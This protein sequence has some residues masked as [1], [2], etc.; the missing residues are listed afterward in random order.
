MERKQNKIPNRKQLMV[1]ELFVV[2]QFTFFSTFRPHST[3]SQYIYICRM[4]SRIVNI[5]NDVYVCD[6][7]LFNFIPV[8]GSIQYK[9][10]QRL[11]LYTTQRSSF[12]FCLV[13]S[14]CEKRIFQSIARRYKKCIKSNK[15]P[16]YFLMF[17]IEE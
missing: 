7:N 1:H 2:A 4:A 11:S 6:L 12:M 16:M 13:R 9:P 14:L 5:S 15:K 8:F 10:L 17:S 3:L